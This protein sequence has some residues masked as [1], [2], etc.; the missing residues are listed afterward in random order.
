MNIPNKISV[1]WNSATS[2]FALA[3]SITVAHAQ[4]V[5]PTI[6]EFTKRA[7]GTIEVTNISKEPKIVSCAAQGFDPDERG[8]AHPHAMPSGLNVRL[9]SGRIEL[10]GNGT[11]QI[12]FDATS[13]S[14][15]AWFLMTCSFVPVQRS[16]G[17]TIAMDVSSI[18]VIH[19]NDFNA[20]QVLLHA[21]HVG[22]KVELELTNNGPGLARVNAG[23][24][25][26]HRTKAEFG[27][28]LL[29]P[30]QRRVTQVDWK[31]SA[32]PESVRV[33]IGK[34]HLETAVN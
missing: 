34:K 25:I 33:Q 7:R 3:M 32:P 9:S 17:L 28:F 2:A 23:E 12:S 29:Y 11:R 14:S 24:V 22:E 19:D 31:Q 16:A 21:R 13:A 1:S 4:Q 20:N 30:H 8:A 10:P 6:A 15:P 5:S 18:V 26:G 27:T